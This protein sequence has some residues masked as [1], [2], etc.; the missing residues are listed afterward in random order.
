LHGFVLI[1]AVLWFAA[2]LA[3][4]GASV[5]IV[6][7]PANAIGFA[8]ALWLAVVSGNR[9]NNRWPAMWKVGVHPL[10]RTVQWFLAAQLSIQVG[11]MVPLSSWFF[12]RFPMAGIFVNLLAIP[13]VG[14][15]VQL[16]LLTGLAGLLPFGAGLL[17][18]PLGAAAGLAGYA[19]IWLAHSG[20]MLFPYPA[21][22]KPTLHWMVGYYSVIGCLLLMDSM[23]PRIQAAW[24]RIWPH[25]SGKKAVA[26][27]S[28][29][30]PVALT[31]VPLLNLP[32][33]TAASLRKVACLSAP[34]YPVVVAATDNS[35][36]VVFNAGDFRFG[37]RTL[38]SAIRNMGAVR[39][40]PAIICGTHPGAGNEG[41]SGL[42]EKMCVEKCYLPVVSQDAD[43]YLDAVGDE[44]LQ[45]K[46]KQGK[47]WALEYRQAYERLFRTA[48]NRDVELKSLVTGNLVDLQGLE[49]KVLPLPDTMP[50]RFVSSA[51]AR[52]LEM[53]T[54]G[55]KWLIVTD[56][57]VGVAEDVLKERGGDYN[58]V[59]LPT[60]DY[61][62][63]YGRLV[64][65]IVELAG[66]ENVIFSGNRVPSGFDLENWS[67]ARPHIEVFAT[68]RDGAV[69]GNRTV[70]GYLVLKAYRTG[71]TACVRRVTH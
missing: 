15:I 53:N 33:G 6:L 7:E 52:L 44:Y 70:S 50:E 16:G 27:C 30:A 9:L 41:L 46:A 34:Q 61:R 47:P 58:V 14:V 3:A 18:V 45:R 12:G 64:D 40:S 29:A 69:T 57:T 20:A 71:R 66:A 25:L 62:H 28:I 54:W 10:P 35:S 43:Q 55:F 60:L 24:Y 37:E 31:L 19:F 42:I 32:G 63:S 21:T 5:A 49:A 1:F 11:M 2:L 13:M 67:D 59:V 65:T 68:W 4:A 39:V 36:A 48:S 17:A 51:S 56:S 22:P 8:G 38:F 23:G 26:V